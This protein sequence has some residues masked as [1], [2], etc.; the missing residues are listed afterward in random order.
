VCDQEL[1]LWARLEWGAPRTDRAAS[2]ASAARRK[3]RHGCTHGKGCG[4]DQG[5][6]GVCGQELE[7]W[8]RLEWGAPRTGPPERAQATK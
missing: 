8:T 5:H 7:V 3:P 6:G 1:E 2:A 4:C